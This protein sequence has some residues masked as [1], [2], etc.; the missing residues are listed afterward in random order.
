MTLTN[1]QL[2]IIGPW[3]H[4]AREDVNVFDPNEKLDPSTSAQD[5]LIQCYLSHEVMSDKPSALAGKTLLYFTMGENK[6]KATHEWPIAGTRRERLYLQA[7]NGL[8]AAKP[9]DSGQDSYKVDFEASAGLANRWSTQ[10]GGPRVDYGDRSIAD[11]KL[12]TYTSAPLARNMEMTGQPVITLRITSTATDGNFF[13]YLEDAGPDGKTTYITEGELRALH[14]KLSIAT[15]PYK[16]T[17][18]YRTFSKDD[19]EALKPGNVATLTFQ[20]Q[21]TSVL[22]REGHRI[23]LAIAGAD[24]GTFLRIPAQGDVTIHVV[25]GG[26]EPSYVDLPIIPAGT[27]S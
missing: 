7:G 18:P 22:F 12:L 21:A 6:W 14:R 13:A 2:T 8:T 16:T 9:S 17:Y 3:T 27:G 24:N 20:L 10:F 26:S 19:S 23:Q 25:R 4:G 11:R 15:P 1:A 5:Q